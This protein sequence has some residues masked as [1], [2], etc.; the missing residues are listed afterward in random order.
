MEWLLL[1]V[2]ALLVAANA[3][4]VAAEFSL[5]TVDRSTVAQAADRGDRGAGSVA[6]ALSTLSTQLSGAQLGITVTSLAVGFIAEPSLA[7]LL[8]PALNA[9]G[10]GEDAAVGVSLTLALLVATVVQMV[11]GELVPKNLAIARPL[12]VA[13]RVAPAQ[14]VFTRLSRPLLAV[15]NGSANRLVRLMGIE[16][17][18]ELRSAR[19]PDELGSLVQRSA[20]EGTLDRPAAVLLSRSLAFGGRTPRT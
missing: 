15:L 4:F 2:A 9:L 20:Q 3:V 16:P 7:T 13:L 1:G 17:Q 8:R 14:R 19:A 18:E 12:P 10:L 6:S 11:L 5:V